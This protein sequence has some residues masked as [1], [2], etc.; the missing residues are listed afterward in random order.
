MP[1]SIKSFSRLAWKKYGIALTIDCRGAQAAK[2][3][4]PT[5]E[6]LF[7]FHC[8]FYYILVLLTSPPHALQYVHLYPSWFVELVNCP[9]RCETFRGHVAPY[10]LPGPLLPALAVIAPE[11]KSVVAAAKIAN[12]LLIAFFMIITPFKIN[13][14]GYFLAYTY[15]NANLKQNV[16]VILKLFSKKYRNWQIRQKKMTFSP[17]VGFEPMSAHSMVA[18]NDKPSNREQERKV[19]FNPYLMQLL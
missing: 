10:L 6:E 14:W 19:S 16:T 5:M 11:T 18:K 1:L 9:C 4:L 17:C 2:K 7:L 15:S 8:N 3:A 13:F 12:V